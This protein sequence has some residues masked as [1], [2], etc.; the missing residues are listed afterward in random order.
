MVSVLPLAP[1]PAP[2]VTCALDAIQPGGE[3]DRHRPEQLRRVQRAEG[4]LVAQRGPGAL[5]GEGDAQPD[6]IEQAQLLGD[7]QRRRI[8]QLDEA[9][10]E[11]AR[12]RPALGAGRGGQFGVHGFGWHAGGPPAGK[13]RCGPPLDRGQQGRGTIGAEAPTG[14][15]TPLRAVALRQESRKRSRRVKRFA[16]FDRQ[17]YLMP[18]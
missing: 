8:G 14:R 17:I 15:P 1:S 10:A 18:K 4:Q 7:Q 9:E 3:G 12:G 6:G 11:R 16:R 5:G 2:T 13:A